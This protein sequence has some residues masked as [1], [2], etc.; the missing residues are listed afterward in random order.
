MLTKLYIDNFR[1]F[2]NFEYR[3]GRRELILGHNG[4]GK[5][6]LVDAFLFLRRFAT[7]GYI[8][9][10][11]LGILNERTRWMNQRQQTW[12]LAALLGGGAYVY[13]LVI[14]PFGEPPQ[15]RVTTETVHLDGK[16]IFEFQ[17]GEVHLFN[18]QF[19]HKVTYPFDWRRSAL[20]TI[21]P[22]PE[23]QKLIGFIRWFSQSLCFKI[24]P[25]A[26]GARAEGEETFPKVDLSNFAEWY[27]HLIQNYPRENATLLTSLQS[28][29]EEFSVLKLESLGENIRIL[30]AEFRHAHDPPL[31]F[32]FNELSDGQ[33]C[34]ICLY[35][36]LHFV[37][38]RGHTIILDEPDN[39]VSLRE[40]QPWLNAVSDV[41]DEGKGQIL[42][43]SHHPELMNQWAPDFGVR[44]VREG[45]GPVRV[46]KFNIEPSNALSPSEVVAR[47][48]ENE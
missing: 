6:S 10:D 35:A 41:L 40:I 22:R 13:R 33:R 1:C 4:S 23:N 26:M 25:L 44:F 11:G 48:W 12:E 42:I 7:S 43:I 3:P 47:G 24:N 27:R 39:F 14:E 45:I 18:D 16:P 8:I 38:A 19:Q 28:V 21:I 5:S 15:I 20:A 37:I 36:I 29:L 34:L 30:Q 31:K 46:T 9:E 17:K 32:N 2:V